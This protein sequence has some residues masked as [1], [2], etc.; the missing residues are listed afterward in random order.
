MNLQVYKKDNLFKISVLSDTLIKNL[1][2]YSD[3]GLTFSNNYFDVVPGEY[4]FS[5]CNSNLDEEEFI[6]KLK[7]F[8]MAELNK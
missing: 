1:Y 4:E 8:S 7:Y 5:Y 2:L 6:K 3:D